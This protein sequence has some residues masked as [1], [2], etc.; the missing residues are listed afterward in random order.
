MI[1][2]SGRWRTIDWCVARRTVARTR[3]IRRRRRIAYW[4][5]ALAQ[6][7][8]GER[9]RGQVE[10]HAHEGAMLVEA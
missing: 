2:S 6:H 4:P 9:A 8:G 7:D 10:G 5:D 1:R 3:C